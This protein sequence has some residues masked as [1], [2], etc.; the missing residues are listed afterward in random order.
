MSLS[1]P[2]AGHHA[3]RQGGAGRVH[4]GLQ[5]IIIMMSFHYFKYNAMMIPLYTTYYNRSD[6][7]TGGR[8]T[9]YLIIAISY[10]WFEKFPEKGV[11]CS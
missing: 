10:S 1:Q 2:R 9:N 4:H 6:G 5:V 11:L 3:A 8:L 7:V